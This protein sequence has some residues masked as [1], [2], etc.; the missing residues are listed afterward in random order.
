MP[1]L[2]IHPAE[3]ESLLASF[4]PFLS[5]RFPTPEKTK[6]GRGRP[7]IGPKWVLVALGLIKSDVL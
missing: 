2:C 4:K 5:E 3:L 7:L 1:I 6:N